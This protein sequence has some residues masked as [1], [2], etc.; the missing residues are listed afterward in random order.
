MYIQYIIK[1]LAMSIINN[2]CI[3]ERFRLSHHQILKHHHLNA[4]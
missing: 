3:Y 2:D 4:Y 1:N